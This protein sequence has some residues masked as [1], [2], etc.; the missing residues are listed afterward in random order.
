MG[1]AAHVRPGSL[2]EEGASA[3]HGVGLKQTVLLPFVTVGSLVNF[4]DCLMAGGTGAGDH[5]EVGSGYVHFNFTPQQ[6]KATASLLGDVPHAVMLDRPPIFLGGQGGLVGPARIAF[7]TL[8]AAGVV[9]RHDILEEGLL[10]MGRPSG[11]GRTRAFRRDRYSGVERIFRNNLHYIGNIRALQAWYRIARRT[12]MTG[13]SYQES[14][15]EGAIA[16]LDAIL[17]ERLRR[18]GHVADVLSNTLKDREADSEGASQLRAVEAYRRLREAWS[19]LQTRLGAGG[20][21]VPG[22][23]EC[24]SFLSGWQKIPPLTPYAEAVASLRPSAKAAGT[25]WLQAIVDEVVGFLPGRADLEA[26]AGL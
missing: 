17:E 2:L 21:D 19:G 22:A 1:S 6:D 4:C 7:G 13:D 9:C 25:A 26:R 16:R 18:L 3:A 24:E 11:G 8:V 15:C 20:P 10:Y 12:L 14:C 5:S 23:R